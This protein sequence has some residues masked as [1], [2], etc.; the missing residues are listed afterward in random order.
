MTMTDEVVHGTD[1]EIKDKIKN[2][3]LKLLQHE[4]LKRFDGIPHKLG[5]Q[6]ALGILV[7]LMFNGYKCC[8]DEEDIHIVREKFLETTDI[9][10]MKLELEKLKESKTHE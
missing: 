6:V 1:K 7:S 8:M 2:D 3:P 10:R 9:K 4:M 5:V